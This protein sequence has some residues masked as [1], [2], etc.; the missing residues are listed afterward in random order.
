MN[1]AFSHGMKVCVDMSFDNDAS[2]PIHS[3]TYMY[4][5]IRIHM[6]IGTHTHTHTQTHRHTRR[7]VHLLTL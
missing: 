3:G 6:Y 1:L 5:Y 7:H 2:A 4:T